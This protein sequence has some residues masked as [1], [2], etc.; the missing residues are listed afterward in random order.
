MGNHI[1]R[2]YDPAIQGWFFISTYTDS[3][4]NWAAN[5]LFFVELVDE[6]VGPRIWRIAPTLNAFQGYWS[7]AFASLD[8]QARYVYWGANWEGA[9]NL[10]LYRA[11]LCHR[12]WETLNSQ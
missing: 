8:F 12:W 5:Q 3:V 4:S 10:E 11:R 1:G 7:E 2:I 9:S 6:T